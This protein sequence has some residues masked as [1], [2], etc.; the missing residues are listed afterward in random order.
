MVFHRCELHSLNGTSELRLP[1]FPS[2]FWLFPLDLLLRRTCWWRIRSCFCWCFRYSCFWFLIWV[3]WKDCHPNELYTVHPQEPLFY[4]DHAICNKVSKWPKFPSGLWNTSKN[5]VRCKT[6]A[7][8]NLTQLQSFLLK[9]RLKRK[10]IDI[11]TIRSFQKA[12]PKI[13]LSSFFIFLSI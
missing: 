1:D 5:Y 3:S 12:N 7:Q 10:K 6:N 8:T 13:Y 11:T 9:L 2:C 4:W